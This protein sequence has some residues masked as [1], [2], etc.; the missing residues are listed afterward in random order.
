MALLS[1]RGVVR[2]A[3]GDAAKLLQGIVTNDMALL[4]RQAAIHGGLLTPQG[5]IL[6]EFF[7]VKA[8]DGYLLET[9]R[10]STAELIK[11]LKLYRLRASVDIAEDSDYRVLALWGTPAPHWPPMADTFA[12][13][14]P[15]RPE[16]RARILT[17]STQPAE[18]AA[19]VGASTVDALEY[20]AHRIALGVPEGGKDYA[21]GDTFAHE[22]NFDLLNGISFSKGCFVGQEV[23][24]RVQHRGTARKRIVQIE[25]DAPLH[26]GAEVTAGTASI[27]VIGSVS[28][29]RGL[30]LLRVDRAAE[31]Q[32]KSEPLAANGVRISVRDLASA[33]PAP[34]KPAPVETA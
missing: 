10:D 32:A 11:R 34:A 14:D 4:E 16:L 12:F 9:D 15:R 1:D 7:I 29:R 31:A 20:H 26:S 5:K 25:G 2:L 22:A 8:A 28:G 30:A 27:G 21:L 33:M 13:P 17:R 6:F 18:L 19:A 23:V 3:G 24:S